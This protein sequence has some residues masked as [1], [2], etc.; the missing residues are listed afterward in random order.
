M[1]AAKGPASAAMAPALGDGSQ[2]LDSARLPVSGAKRLLPVEVLQGQ[3]LSKSQVRA[4]A[5]GAVGV[6]ALLL[7]AQMAAAPFMYPQVQSLYYP[8]SLFLSVS[9]VVVSIVRANVAVFDVRFVSVAGAAMVV[10]SGL[11]AFVGTAT[12]ASSACLVVECLGLSVLACAWMDSSFDDRDMTATA[13]L[14]AGAF[15]AVLAYFGLQTSGITE[16]LPWQPGGVLPAGETATIV[17]VAERVLVIALVVGLPA[18]STVLLVVA[19]GIRSRA[20]EESTAAPVS[21]S[22]FAHNSATARFP[23]LQFAAL[24]GCS[25]ACS[26]FIGM[27]TNPFII[28]SRT[29][30]NQS[31]VTAVVVCFVLFALRWIRLRLSTVTLF[32]ATSICLCIGLAMYSMGFGGDIVRSLFFICVANFLLHLLLPL[33]FVRHGN[34]LSPQ[35]A[36]PLF[37]LSA[38]ICLSA[39][40]E[41]VGLWVASNWRMGVSQIADLGLVAMLV[42]MMATVWMVVAE[43]RRAKRAADRAADQAAEGALAAEA[44]AVAAHERARQMVEEA[45]VDAAEK[46]RIAEEAAQAAE[47]AARIAEEAMRVAEEARRSEEKARRAEEEALAKAQQAESGLRVVEVAFET[48]AEEDSRLV[49]FFEEHGLSAR[50]TDVMKLVAKHYPNSAIAEKLYITERTV[51]FHISNSYSKLGVHSRS[52]LVLAIEQFMNEGR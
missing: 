29:L 4:A 15:M 37:L 23:W 48:S 32:A 31:L 21:V 12:L 14:V 27:N 13:S 20:G 3:S 43:T 6:A 50:E 42:V 45:R 46:A 18:I 41:Q 25:L 5:A 35:V 26:I 38:S 33:L 7:W 22:E 30:C 40:G 19:Q 34:V 2:A 10:S 8:S 24:V 28:N 11:H 49:A 36:C 16:A 17:P 44:A 1:S 47:Q 9:L 51:K 52:E 39:V